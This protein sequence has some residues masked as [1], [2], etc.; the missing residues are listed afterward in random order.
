M[1]NLD[2]EN[3]KEI[4]RFSFFFSSSGKRQL[5]L[6][7][8]EELL[9][10]LLGE[11]SHAPKF[12]EFLQQQKNYKALNLDQWMG[13]LEFAKVIGSYDSDFEGYDVQDPCKRFLVVF[14]HS[15]YL[16][17]SFRACHS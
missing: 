13:F 9:V 7:I 5:E 2:H 17:F 6:E 1:L 3:Y 8:A 4:F 11:S 10:L 12:S 14:F 15:I 16:M